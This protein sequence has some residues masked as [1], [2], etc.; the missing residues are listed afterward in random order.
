MFETTLS[1]ER[2]SLQIISALLG[3]VIVAALLSYLLLPQVKVYRNALNARVVLLQVVATGDQMEVDLRRLKEEI[4][5]LEKRLHGDAAN[6]PAQQMEAYILGQLQR[7]A[8]RNRVELMGVSP[9]Q[10]NKVDR[11]GEMLFELKM[12]GGYFDVF[13]LL[14]DLGR[15]LGFVVVKFYRM[16]PQSHTEGEPLINVDMTIAAYRAED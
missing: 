8:W 13:N 12:A 10:G 5:Q 6:L 14:A 3:L 4:N 1:I 7:A 16:T 11:F 9:K 15:E 2:R